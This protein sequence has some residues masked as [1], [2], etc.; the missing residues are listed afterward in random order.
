MSENWIYA[1]MPA[2]AAALAD[3]WFPT[4]ILFLQTVY[5]LEHAVV[6]L[7]NADAKR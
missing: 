5:A 6:E 4:V 7:R 1:A 3:H 2:L